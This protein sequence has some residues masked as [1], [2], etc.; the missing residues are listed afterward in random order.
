M[1][2]H[3]A[4]ECCGVEAVYLCNPHVSH[5]TDVITGSSDNTQHQPILSH[6][7]QHHY[8]TPC[9]WWFSSFW[10]LLGGP[11]VLNETP[12]KVENQKMAKLQLLCE[13]QSQLK[14]LALL[15]EFQL[16]AHR[17][18]VAVFSPKHGYLEK[19]LIS[20][21]ALC[22]CRMCLVYVSCLCI[23]QCVCVGT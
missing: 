6:F 20:V 10:P 17:K 11:A 15:K 16:D 1:H 19:L 9:A 22:C 12:P 23:H 3:W 7:I 8:V 14:N 13:L 5:V 2:N 21:C 4:V 18:R